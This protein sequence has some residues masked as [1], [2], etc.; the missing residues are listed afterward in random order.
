MSS[1]EYATSFLPLNSG[2]LRYTE[3]TAASGLPTNAL[4]WPGHSCFE[5]F[6][7]RSRRKQWKTSA[8]EAASAKSS[9]QGAAEGSLLTSDVIV[10]VPSESRLYGV[11]SR[12]RAARYDA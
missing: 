9:S 7:P 3:T 6:L 5:G 11:S 2:E 12:A 1:I 10:S 8:S 4:M